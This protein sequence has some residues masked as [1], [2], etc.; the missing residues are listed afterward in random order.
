MNRDGGVHL[1]TLLMAI[2]YKVRALPSNS[3]YQVLIGKR[4]ATTLFFAF[5]NDIT[6]LLGLYPG[7]KK[8][9]WT[10]YVDK[11]PEF[12][13]IDAIYRYH[14]NPNTAR[15]VYQDILGM[16]RGLILP[17][18][19]QKH[20]LALQ[21]FI[22]VLT[23]GQNEENKYIPLVQDIQ[24][25]QA[26]KGF[27]YLE[28][29]Q[30]NRQLGDMAEAFKDVLESDLASYPDQMTLIFL[31][32]F[33]G[34]Q[35]SA[36]TLDQLAESH[37]LQRREVVIIQQA[38]TDD[39]LHRWLKRGDGDQ[40]GQLVSEFAAYIY[41]AFPVWNQ[42][43]QETVNLLETSASIQDM[44]NRRHLKPS[45][46]TEHFIEVALSD[47]ERI[48]VRALNIL[49]LQS[50]EPLQDHQP[51]ATFEAFLTRFGQNQEYWLYRYWQIVYANHQA[52]VKE[53]DHDHTRG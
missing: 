51:D 15:M 21:L 5:S 37:Q 11:V 8:Q 12:P 49:G 40:A 31:Q 50:I 36:L 44:A 41:Q 48:Q 42:S 22:Q 52:V 17:N 45:T 26:V 47:P 27:L 38:L 13:S 23:Y 7:L 35:L 1:D 6:S 4:T 20:Q 53:G 32:Q 9:A 10:S 28:K 2:A 25:Q 14:D 30:K 33:E 16:R 3:V 39:L 43:T 24:V 46:I 19:H 18:H 34:P 29:K